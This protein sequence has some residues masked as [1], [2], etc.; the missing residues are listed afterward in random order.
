MKAKMTLTLLCVVV[1]AAGLLTFSGASQSPPPQPIE[2]PGDLSKPIVPGNVAKA[3]Y[4]D[5]YRAWY[6]WETATKTVIVKR[7]ER[8][9]ATSAWVEQIQDVSTAYFVVDVR[10]LCETAN[11]IAS[12][13]IAGVYP[14]GEACIERWSFTYPPPPGGGGYVPIDQRRLPTIRKVELFRGAQYGH[15]RCIEPDPE[16]RFVLFLT[17]E[18]PTLYRRPLPS[19]AITTELTQ[20]TVSQLADACSLY[21]AQHATE[22]RQFH[23]IRGTRWEAD[24]DASR[25]IIVLKDGNNDTVFDSPVVLTPT[26]WSQQGYDGP[27]VWLQFCQ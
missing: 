4:S 20:S 15:I 11:S 2:P 23:L 24:M 21:A 1:F 22:G 19:G 5:L 7:R 17:Y 3:Y 13:F 6:D 12:L 26:Q 27:G 25:V 10:S 9:S 16:G 8:E 14:N 18:T